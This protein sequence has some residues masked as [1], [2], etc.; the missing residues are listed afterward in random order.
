M[1]N[2]ERNF[3]ASEVNDLLKGLLQKVRD[4]AG[5]YGFG[6]KRFDSL[7]E[8]FSV[9]ELGQS[10]LKENPD[11]A[12]D[13]EQQAK[14]LAALADQLDN[15]G[16]HKEA[17]STRNKAEAIRQG[18]LIPSEETLYDLIKSNNS[19]NTLL[20]EF[21]DLENKFGFVTRSI[22][23]QELTTDQQV[24]ALEIMAIIYVKIVELSGGVVDRKKTDSLVAKTLH[25]SISQIPLVVTYAKS[26]SLLIEDSKAPEKLRIKD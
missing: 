16:L 18:T 2:S 9:S 24:E 12:S 23:L 19:I 21:G 10:V 1:T 13:D 25:V 3:S 14:T 20:E 26:A 11:D 17:T 8:D 15:H 6:S 5:T 4:K 22:V 7:I